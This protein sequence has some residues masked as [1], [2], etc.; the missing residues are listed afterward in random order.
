MTE[1]FFK[2]L[3]YLFFEEGTS[4]YQE[5]MDSE[6][7]FLFN[8]LVDNIAGLEKCMNNSILIKDDRGERIYTPLSYEVYHSDS[9][10]VD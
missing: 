8:T 6:A 2:D 9:D 4:E 5:W 3:I 10:A 7:L 1:N